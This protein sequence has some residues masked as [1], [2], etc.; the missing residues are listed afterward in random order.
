RFNKA[1]LRELPLAYCYPEALP[2]DIDYLNLARRTWPSPAGDG[3]AERRSFP[4]IYAA[5][6]EEAAETLAPLIGRYLETGRF[7]HSETA[8]AIGNGGLSLQDKTGRPQAPVRAAP[9]PLDEVLARQH[10]LRGG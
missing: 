4:E 5:A 3:A 2:L 6:V 8:A 1:L 9:L 7:P 10:R